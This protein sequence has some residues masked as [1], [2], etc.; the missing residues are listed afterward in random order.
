MNLVDVL[1]VML[2]GYG[3]YAGY[4]RGLP[5]VAADSAGFFLSTVLAA[6]TYKQFAP[7]VGEWLRLIPS[8]S[9]VVSFSLI[10][11][12]T[13]LIYAISVHHLLKKLPHHLHF[14]RLSQWSG[15]LLS[16]AKTALII[17]IVLII[18]TGLPV[19]APWKGSVANAV[20]SKVLLRLGGNLERQVNRIVGSSITDTLNFFT[21]R[22]TSNESVDLGFKTTAVKTAPNIEIAM[23]GL[24][25]QERASRGLKTLT[26]NEKAREVARTHSRD[27][28]AR[29]Y[30][31][32]INPDGLDPFD[33]MEAGGVSYRAAG[34]N[35]ALA[36]SLELAHNG[37]M[38][39]PGHKANILSPDFG[40]VGIGVI[41][42]GRYGL[43]FTQ[44]FTD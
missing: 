35:L 37:L 14:H 17:T 18:Y 3:A 9:N 13:E 26:M 15:A 22:T 28:F 7:V 44:N 24:I 33:R 19:G 6:L 25:N 1:I 32:H 16:A 20:T 23:L 34:E 8:F 4:Y 2:L 12:L 39:S 27:M 40:A 5:I 29:G 10:F 21:V 41:D 38:N 30:F 11:V 31:S 36:P 42:G 43:M